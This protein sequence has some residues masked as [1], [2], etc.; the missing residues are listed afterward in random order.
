M[1]SVE[2]TSIG[3]HRQEM[4][5]VSEV[6]GA[7]NAMKLEAIELRA[8]LTGLRGAAGAHGRETGLVILQATEDSVRQRA[9]GVGARS[10]SSEGGKESTSGSW[11][12]VDSAGSSQGNVRGR[13][14]SRILG[15]I[16][17]YVSAVS[18]CSTVDQLAVNLGSAY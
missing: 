6:P 15:I 11:S 18:R 13:L 1:A 7:K 12:A 5:L 4:G 3:R 16:L 14:G 8:V 2:Q 9:R 10:S 17:D